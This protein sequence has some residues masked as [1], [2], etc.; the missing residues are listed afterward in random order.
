LFALKAAD[1]FSMTPMV[2]PALSQ[3]LERAR[4]RFGLEVEILD[5]GLN[6]MY[7]DGGTDLSRIIE[8]SPVVRRVLLDAIAAGRPQHLQGSASDYR[9]YPLRRSPRRH[10]A[11]LLAVRRAKSDV[12]QALDA[13][14]WSDFARAIVEADL[15]ATE[16]L[17]EEQQRSRRF[18]GTLRFLEFVTEATDEAAL[19]AA[20][21]QA[22]A[23]WYDVDARIYRRTLAGDFVLHTSL[24]GARLEE[25]ARRLPAQVVGADWKLRRLEA[26]SDLRDR[27]AGYEGILVPFG[28]TTPIEWVMALI[29]GV[30]SDADAVLSLVG[31]VSGAQLRALS[32]RRSEEAR[33][34]FEG[35]LEDTAR[36]PE[37]AAL[38]VV[39]A[40]AQTV[41]ASSGSLTLTHRG[42]VRRVAAIGASA[43]DAVTHIGGE[44]LDAADRLVRVLSLG[45]DDRAVLELWTSPGLDFTSQSA[46]VTDVCASVLR[47]WLAGTLSSFDGPIAFLD[48]ANADFSG[49][50]ERIREE[51]ERAKRFDLRLSLVL[52][53]VDVRPETLA[54]LQDAVRRELRGSDVTG[55]MSDSRVAALL[56]HTDA[57]GLGN[58][59]RRLKQRLAGEAGRLNMGTLT[60]GQAAFSPDCRTADALLALA[61][62]QAEPVIVH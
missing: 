32:S 14:P 20:I 58:V 54:H 33:R 23:V 15:A 56:T 19:A 60:L 8:D 57:L 39:H 9:V 18:V 53:D 28:V 48:A 2:S 6:K 21:V 22:A 24:P 3:L 55:T 62:R 40:L 44:H 27:A 7:P 35:L 4:L 16:T 46:S 34:T 41:K 1:A 26:A 52:I 29:G 38:R 37:L 49:F 13:E 17:G 10:A 5:A 12:A 25:T 36:V 43:T 11:G 51:L 30:P 59:V 50:L 45:G 42:R 61:L 31:R 47:T